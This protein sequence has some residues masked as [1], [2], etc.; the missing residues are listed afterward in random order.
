MQVEVRGS[1]EPNEM[2]SQIPE[3]FTLFS[4]PK[5]FFTSYFEGPLVSMK[6]EPV[7]SPELPSKHD[8]L[9]DKEPSWKTP[10]ALACPSLEL[11]RQFETDKS[12]RAFTT[13]A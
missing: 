5:L 9:S 3:D 6:T 2:S 10:M 7:I 11:N 13:T 1:Q 8:F 4:F 12:P